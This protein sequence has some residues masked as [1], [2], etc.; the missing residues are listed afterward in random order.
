MPTESSKKHNVINQPEN[1]TNLSL[2]KCNNCEVDLSTTSKFTICE[3]CGGYVCLK[4][5]VWSEETY[6]VLNKEKFT[7]ISIICRPCKNFP[8]K[9]PDIVKMLKSGEVWEKYGPDG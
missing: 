2:Q 4:C 6:D 5:L 3:R 8:D 7:G 1:K 9:S